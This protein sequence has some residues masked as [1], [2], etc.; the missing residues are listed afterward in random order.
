MQKNSH[1]I[2]LIQSALFCLFMVMILVFI[3]C[4]N[5][6]YLPKGEKLYIGANVHVIPQPKTMKNKERKNLEH[7]LVAL[8]RPRPNT[9]L[10]G[11]WRDKLWFYNIAGKPKG[12]GLRNFIR[13][14]LGEPPV[15]FSQVDTKHNE[16]ILRNHLE[17]K[18]YFMPEV[19]SKNVVDKKGKVTVEYTAKV[20]RPYK[21][22]HIIFPEKDSS[23]NKLIYATKDESFLHPGMQYDLERLKEERDRINTAMKEQGL[24]YFTADDIV[25][26]ADSTAGDHEVDIYVRIKRKTPY[27]A[28]RVYTLN[29]F[30]VYSN[31]SLFQDSFKR[32]PDTVNVLGYY[33]IGNPKTYRPEVI[34]S[35]IFMQKG[36]VYNFEDYDVTL[37][38]LMRLGIYKFV[39][40]KF[41][42]LDTS[43]QKGKLDTYIY[44]TPLPRKSLRVDLRMVSRSDN[45][46]GPLINLSFK[47]RNVF[48]GAELL[49]FNLNGSIEAAITGAEKG[50]SYATVG[51]DVT[52]DIPRFITPLIKVNPPTRYVPNTELK[53]GFQKLSELGYYNLNT[54]NF[55]AGYRW[56]QNARVEH[57]YNPFVINYLKLGNTSSRFDSILKKNIS[58]KRSFETQFVLGS[59]YSYTYNTQAEMDRKTDIFFNGV[60]DESGNIIGLAQSAFS[61]YRSS[62]D[63]PYRVL[64]EPYAQYVLVMGDIRHY[65]NF[66]RSREKRFVSRLFA[67]VGIPYGNSATLPY[68]KEFFTGGNNSVRAYPSR[69]LG[70][71]SYELPTDRARSFFVDQVGDIK[72][73]GNLEYR[74]P[75]Y[76]VFKGAIFTDAGNIWLLREDTA[77]PGGKFN[78]NTFYKEIAVG[79]GF[80]IRIDASYFVLRFD[81]AFPLRKAYPV[82][83]NYWVLSAIKPGDPVWRKNNLVLNIGIGYPF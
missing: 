8:T 33:Y 65:I 40:I 2:Q 30:Y 9:K 61:H 74:F 54:Y 79:S 24:F 27:K 80:G 77:R 71:G 10:F 49:T 82:N 51:G 38:R 45:F 13:T 53:L 4:N 66:K 72:L 32:K 63:H 60:F 58:L 20:D 3:S 50:R 17:N 44:L 70:P 68:I 62:P 25:F 18:G 7:E 81:L 41:K 52:L 5:T 15:L 48:R 1:N 73:E 37:N 83:G 56:H 12:K 67:G 43:S 16:E 42:D 69:L 14:K 64:G 36:A 6:K 55:S 59:Y 39:N 34:V 35:S 78:I 76:S 21:F 19:F 23:I 11:I 28:T 22:K 31:H 46:A 29:N 57:L 75:I 47:N 26:R